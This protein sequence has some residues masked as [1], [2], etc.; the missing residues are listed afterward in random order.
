M[1]NY[2]K[3]PIIKVDDKP[4]IQVGYNSIIEQIKSEPGNVIIECYPGTD[5]NSLEQN[6]IDGLKSDYQVVFIDNYS[7]SSLEIQEYIEKN[8]TDDRVFG[9]MS[10]ST[11]DE[12]YEVQ[13]LEELKA[14]LQDTKFLVYGFG[15]IQLITDNSTL[16]YSNLTR[17]EIQ[18]RHRNGM[19]NWKANNSGEEATRKFKRGFFFEWRV[20]DRI[21]KANYHRIDYMLDLNNIN[22]PKLISG[23]DYRKGIAA[24]VNT[25]FRLVPFFD[26]GVWGGQWMKE[27]FN[28]DNSKENYAWSFDGVP[29]E[30]SVRLQF[31]PDFVEI[32][33]IDL[34]FF[35][36]QKLLGDRVHARFGT[37]FPIRFDFLDTVEG[38]NLSLQVHPL[39]EYI[40]EKF[41]MNYTQDESYYILDTK[42]SEEAYV[43]LGTK[44]GINS[45]EFIKDLNYCQNHGET[46]D[47]EKYINR[48][49]CKKHDH[50]LIPAGTIHCSGSNV[51]VL[52]ISATPYIFTFKL[53]DWDRVG[54]D[55]KPRPIHIEHGEKVIDFN[56]DTKFVHKEL[57]NN[58]KKISDIEER[59]GLHE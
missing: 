17:W 29:E 47:V 31:G 58:F 44:E 46:F 53:W 6:V 57:V 21:K 12:F 2:V 20:A 11:I 22:I 37:E 9:Y 32:P 25:P 39:T 50:F 28:L 59:T 19:E 56:R 34:V 5:I 10:N 35:E 33:A 7:K 30:N 48:I 16:Y 55:G 38:Q 8:I 18:T 14:S 41:G 24:A 26:P 40:Q 45:D 36:P 42:D 3:D 13:V 1:T 23:F 43:Y 27:K 51:M 15:A 54:L 49:P 4:K 52:E